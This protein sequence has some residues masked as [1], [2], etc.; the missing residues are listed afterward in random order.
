MVRSAL[1]VERLREVLTYHP[2]TGEFWRISPHKKEHIG[3][4]AGCIKKVGYRYI[5]IDNK[6]Y[7]AHRLAYLYME[8]CWPESEIDHINSDR[9]DNRWINLRPASSR[10]NKQNR[11]FK[12]NH[13]G[14][15]N[16]SAP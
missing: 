3:V 4:P 12:E 10:Q 15:K 5:S 6:S 1:T 7:L 16:V 14:V 8:D 9:S 2:N 13:L 11:R